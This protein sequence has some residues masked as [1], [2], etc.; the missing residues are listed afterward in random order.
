M[1]DYFLNMFGLR[2]LKRDRPQAT[3]LKNFVFGKKNFLDFPA[4]HFLVSKIFPEKFFGA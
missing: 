3:N 4:D 2:K 1:F